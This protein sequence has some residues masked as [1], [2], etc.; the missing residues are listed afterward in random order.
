MYHEAQKTL[1]ALLMQVCPCSHAGGCYRLTPR[2]NLSGSRGSETKINAYFGGKV[3]S[4]K[5]KPQ[6]I[7]SIC[8]GQRARGNNGRPNNGSER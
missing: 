4:S 3:T 7:S 1:G 6:K 5:P 2:E 8:D